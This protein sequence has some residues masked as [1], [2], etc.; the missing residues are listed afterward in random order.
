MV[1]F[2][3]TGGTRMSTTTSKNPKI[4]ARTMEAGTT[5]EHTETEAFEAR[6]QKR[7]NNS[8][9]L[10]RSTDKIANDA[11]FVRNQPIPHGKEMFP[12]EWRMQFIDLFYPYALDEKGNRSPLY[13]DIPG[14]LHE[15]AMCERKLTMMRDKG[16]RYTYLKMGEAEW[17][18]R[19]RLDGQDPDKIKE[20]Q[21][22]LRAREEA[23]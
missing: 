11:F 8:Q 5:R 22:K 23:I 6:V 16:M 15:V 17:E 18:G 2:E 10:T 19:M 1:Q 7:I 14:N 12:A 21:A 4:K 20:D 9:V 3:Q 13:I